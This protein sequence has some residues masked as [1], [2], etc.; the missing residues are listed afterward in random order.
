[1]VEITGTQLGA[2]EER[3]FTD[4]QRRVSLALLGRLVTGQRTVFQERV[5]Q[6]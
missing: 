4:R 6:V 1:M 5:K 3:G 2:S